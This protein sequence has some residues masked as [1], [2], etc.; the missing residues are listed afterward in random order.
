MNRP[1][2]GSDEQQI[3]SEMEEE[4]V[5]PICTSCGHRHVLGT[6]CGICGHVGRSQIYS[7][8]RVRPPQASLFLPST[9][10]DFQAKALERRLIRS[11]SYC[12]SLPG[13]TFDWASEI[14]LLRQAAFVINYGIP[15]GAEFD[16]LDTE[17]RHIV[18][19]G[20]VY[21]RCF[22]FLYLIIISL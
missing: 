2:A 13:Q 9:K 12:Q 16:G 14:R 3:H 17:L 7:K 6:K 20:A 5:V 19:T 15:E 11:H 18:V 22:D 10:Q 4:E 1:G 21:N 8:M